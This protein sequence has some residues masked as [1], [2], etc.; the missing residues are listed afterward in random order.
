MKIQNRSLFRPIHKNYRIDA[1]S[2]KDTTI[3]LYDEIGMWGISAN[4]FVQDFDKITSK[5]I[6][7]RINSP[8]GSVFDG[9]TIFNAI[10]RHPSTVNVY[11]DG[12]A[13]SIASIIALAGDSVMIAETGF[14][15]VHDPW[16]VVVGSAKDMRKEA[17]LLEKVEGT[18]VNVYATRS[19][20]DEQQIE[21]IMA[22]ETW[23][24]A[25]EAKEAGFIDGIYDADDDQEQIA[26]LFD[27]S[28]FNKT[29]ETLMNKKP[30][31]SKRD[32][33]KALRDAGLSNNQAKAMVANYKA[34]DVQHDD[35]SDLK[36]IFDNYFEKRKIQ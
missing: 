3:Y 11:I 29:P 22:D 35:D 28:V 17:D 2:G 36:S 7:L 15:M 23:Y 20:M 1:K 8:G 19:G 18:L 32:I 26:A 31:P 30:E 24:T 14:Y 9:M 6:N 27:L 10:K 34:R 4:R 5:T 33:E 25:D 13:A 12:L 21:N 16:S